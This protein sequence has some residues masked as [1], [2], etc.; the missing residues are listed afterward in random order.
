MTQGPAILRATPFHGRAAA[1]NRD[2]AWVTRNGATLSAH[3]AG[4]AGEALAARLNVAMVDI[5]WRWRLTVEG[6]RADA[7]LNHLVT[8]D[9]AALAP[10]GALKALWLADGGGVRGAGVVARFGRESFQIVAGAEDAAW[11]AEA[12]ARFEVRVRDVSAETG[13]LALIGPYSGMTLK[14][15]GLAPEIAQLSFR[16]LS[17][18]GIEVMLSRFGEHGG[19]EIWCEPDDGYLVWDRLVA[20][21]AAFGIVPVGTEAADLLDLEAG[22]PRP[23]L[24]YLPARDAFAVAPRPA[25]LGAEPLIDP[26]HAGYNGSRAAEAPSRLLVG[27]EIASDV[28]APFTPLALNGREVGHTLRSAYSPAL[29][30]AIALAAVDAAAGAAGTVLSL[31]LPP[32]IDAPSLRT[33]AARVMALP[34]LPAPAPLAL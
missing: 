29:R 20:A 28:P 5:S 9:A 33:A 25:L 8:R 11:I 31:T 6:V 13:G 26:A 16:M 3:Y 19:F 4:A 1:A 30:A 22:V 34:F 2:N 10:G 14:A 15:A 23:F 24:D 7:F 27:I 17:W 21:G 12:A 32:G 18:R